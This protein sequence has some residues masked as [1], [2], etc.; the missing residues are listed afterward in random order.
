MTLPDSARVVTFLGTRNRAKAKAFYCDTLGLK[1]ISED[2]FALVLETDEK[3]LRISELKDFEP[4]R[5]TALGWVVADIVA[6]VRALKEKGV[7]FQII[8]GFGQDADA[9]WTSP[10]KTARV[11]WFLD[12]DGNILSLTQH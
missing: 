9:I 7:A 6:A 11:A 4:R 1:Y 12:P 8:Q 5:F 2:P 3:T 10:D